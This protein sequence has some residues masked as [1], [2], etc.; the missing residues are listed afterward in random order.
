MTLPE[1][2]ERCLS[3]RSACNW[4]MRSKRRSEDNFQAAMG[5][6]REFKRSHPIGG[7]EARAKFFSGIWLQDFNF[8]CPGNEAGEAIKRKL[9]E[10]KDK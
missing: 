10:L 6:L 8:V 4:R 5:R 3:A 7:A 2:I 9:M 1:A